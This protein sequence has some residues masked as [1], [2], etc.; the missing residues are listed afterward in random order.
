MV[1]LTAQPQMGIISVWI[2]PRFIKITL[3]LDINNNTIGYVKRRIHDLTGLPVEQQKLVHRGRVLE[4]MDYTLGQYQIERGVR[5]YMAYYKG[6]FP[7]E[8]LKQPQ[9]V[10][11]GYEESTTGSEGDSID[12][13]N[14]NEI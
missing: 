10:F 11:T 13:N 12:W 3:Y 4:H 2:L 8:P 1:V 6:V 7:R 5:I 14:R 9:S